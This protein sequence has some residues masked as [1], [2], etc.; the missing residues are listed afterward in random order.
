MWEAKWQVDFSRPVAAASEIG[1]SFLLCQ[2]SDSIDLPRLNHPWI[3]GAAGVTS[4]SSYFNFYMLLDVMC[5]CFMKNFCIMCMR[6][7]FNVTS[8]TVRVWF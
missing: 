5:W 8:C 1:L 4:S 7:G 6:D 2:S 3:P